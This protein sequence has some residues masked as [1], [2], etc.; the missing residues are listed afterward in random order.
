MQTVSEEDTERERGERERGG[1]VDGELEGWGG[2]TKWQRR[3]WVKEDNEERERNW[4]PETSR[5]REEK[6]VEGEVKE[7]DT[8]ARKQTNK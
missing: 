6:D 1:G 2:G 3:D 8:Q 4:E 7:P 5:Q